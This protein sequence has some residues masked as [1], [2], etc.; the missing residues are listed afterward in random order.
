MFKEDN[1]D[2]GTRFWKNLREVFNYADKLGIP[3]LEV[4]DANGKVQVKPDFSVPYGYCPHCQAE[5]V[6]R[7]KSPHGND[8]CRLGHIYPMKNTLHNRDEPLHF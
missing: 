7:E 4:V 2:C 6:A 8:K 5:V 3:H 1:R